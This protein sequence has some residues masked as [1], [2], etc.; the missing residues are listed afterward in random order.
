MHESWVLSAGR[1]MIT[2]SG[3]AVRMV[4]PGI[5]AG[6][7][8]PDYR[9]A[10]VVFGGRSQVQ[11]DVELHLFGEDWHRH[12][13]DSDKAYNRVVL[14]VVANASAG[15]TMCVAGGRDV[16]EVVLDV[17]DDARA[18]TLLPCAA[19]SGRDEASARGLLVRAGKARM[20]SRAAVIAGESMG[21]EP[22]K[23][24][25]HGVARALGYAAN[26]EAAMEL[27][28]RLTDTS[29]ETL[30]AQCNGED[31][32]ALA[33]GVAGL[34][35]SQRVPVMPYSCSESAQW[36]A[37]WRGLGRGVS[38]MDAQRWRLSGQYPNNSPVRRVVALADLWPSLQL[39]ADEAPGLMRETGASARPCASALE[40]RFRLAGSRYWRQRSDFGLHTREADLVG[41]S[42]A[43]EIVVNALLPWVA[44]MALVSGDAQL[45]DA[46]LRLYDGYPPASRNAVVR[47]MQRQL[48]LSCGGA[49]AAEQQGMVH[50][51]RE[52]CRH[53][54]CGAC[55]LNTSANAS[56]SPACRQ[57]EDEPY[58]D[59]RVPSGY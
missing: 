57:S 56:P 9:D 16:P 34:L 10:V 26:S 28:R 38:S 48:R 54:R 17:V 44:S 58:D 14:H 7:F 27:G 22:W 41:G 24:L 52:Y 2:R 21:I 49:N 45:L 50:F 19:G 5:P 18:T 12:G 47:H 13:H 55:P 37:W 43:R 35:P 8:G 4:Y 33:L 6:N 25:A 31:R 3:E 51:F 20:L 40:G 15:A 53:G 32:E 59:V 39:I 11:G 23:V 30:M 42:K 46:T 36:D 29:A 1:S